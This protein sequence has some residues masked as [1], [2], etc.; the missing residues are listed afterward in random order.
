MP[1]HERFWIFLCSTKGHI[2]FQERYVNGCRFDILIIT[3]IIT[4]IIIIITIII[5]IMWALE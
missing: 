4:I 2:S 1:V 3:I 5:I